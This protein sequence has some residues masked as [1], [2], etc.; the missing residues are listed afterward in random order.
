MAKK[1]INF[2]IDILIVAVVFVLTDLLMVKVLNSESV[3]IELLIYLVLCAVLFGIKWLV[4][5]RFLKD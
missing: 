1:I 5:K 2:V 3:V 4:C